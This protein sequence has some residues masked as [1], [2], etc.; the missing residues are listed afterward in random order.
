MD[1]IVQ[2]K[3]FGEVSITDDVIFSIIEKNIAKLNGVREFSLGKR[4]KSKLISLGHREKEPRITVEKNDSN[5][6]IINIPLSIEYGIT[7]EDTIRILRNGIKK[8]IEEKLGV[9]VKEINV[10]ILGIEK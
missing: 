8:D 4:A 10:E 6:L 1:E 2:S 5:Q 9:E 3:N 7:I